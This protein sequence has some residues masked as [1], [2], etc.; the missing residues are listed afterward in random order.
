[1]RIEKWLLYTFFLSSLTKVT[2]GQS[3]KSLT[4]VDKVPVNYE[5][6]GG[7]FAVQLPMKF[8]PDGVI[9]V[10]FAGAASESSL[11]LIRENGG[12]A[13]NI[14]LSEIPEFTENDFYDFAPGDGPVLFRV[15]RGALGKGW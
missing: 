9:Y 5:Q 1:M 8:G 14:R 11:T 2:I 10:R 7:S 4:V 3:F 13:S 12:I 15:V 6:V